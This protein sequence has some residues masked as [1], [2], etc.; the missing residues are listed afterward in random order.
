MKNLAVLIWHRSL[1]AQMVVVEEWTHLNNLLAKYKYDSSVRLII[2]LC[3]RSNKFT[4]H[5]NTNR[6]QALDRLN[7]LHHMCTYFAHIVF[8]KRIVIFKS[9]CTRLG[10]CWVLVGC[11][12]YRWILSTSSFQ[13]HVKNIDIVCVK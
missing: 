2:L 8:S 13:Y 12:G 3:P 4:V 1:Q 9:C 5:V 11:L 6:L 7:T 10:C